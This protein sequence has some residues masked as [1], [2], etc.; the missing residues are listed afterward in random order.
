MASTQVYL[1]QAS[2]PLVSVIVLNF[3]GK[4]FLKDCLESLLSLNYPKENLEIILVDNAS[5]DG[6]V[7]FVES[8][9][10]DAKIIKN[11]RNYGF[12]KGNNIGARQASGQYIAFL[13]NDMKVDENWLLELLKPILQS[14]SNEVV[15]TGAKILN[16]N[17]RTI[18][19]VTGTMNFYGHGDQKY[20]GRDYHTDDFNKDDYLLFSCGGSMLID[21]SVFLEVGGFDEDYFAYFEDV[22]LGW[23]LW[24]LGYKVKFASKAIAYHKH[25]G[26]SRGIGD[27]KKLVLYERNS[28]Y[29]IIKN[30]EQV[31]LNKILPVALLLIVKRALQGSFLNRVHYHF[32][33]EQDVNEKITGDTLRQKIF[34]K[35]I[36]LRH[37]SVV[38]K[39]MQNLI[40]NKPIHFL[41]KKHMP[42]SNQDCLP[43]TGASRLIALEDL[44]NNIDNIMK[45]REK[46]QRLRKRSDKE[47]FP[48]FREPL[49]A[50]FPG[51]DLAVIQDKLTTRFNILE[52]FED[53]I[54]EMEICDISQ[55]N[56]NEVTE[57][58][59][60][61]RSS[62]QTFVCSFQNLC[63]IEIYMATHHRE[64]K[65]DA[66]FYLKEGS[67]SKKKIDQ[68]RIPAS[69]IRDNEWL[70]VEF[71]PLRNSKNKEY[72]F[73]IDSPEAKPGESFT[74]WHDSNNCGFRGKRF[75]NHQ[76]VEGAL[77]FQAYCK[78]GKKNA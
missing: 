37:F 21:K 39:K 60:G 67:G 17:G 29:T 15:C 62:G 50:S 68:K 69:A 44:M 33:Y 7:D 42:Y 36:K 24:I 19:F 78:I 4:R 65:Y 18:D 47:I 3:N 73:Y 43:R 9:Y 53:L 71:P 57:E 20:F 56:H 5:S 46:I 32:E 28:L 35:D 40:T 14:K 64:N 34:N 45:K 77:T 30:Y 66:Y 10:K 26:T 52:L 41:S 22:D 11:D 8:N 70:K 76:A 16:W 25:Q 61:S 48:L 55:T 12:A 51:K 27:E 6:S 58:I 38:F 72:Y 49:K 75:Q 63:R 31:H 54:D 59:M 1:T 74:I 2:L 13:N 23:R